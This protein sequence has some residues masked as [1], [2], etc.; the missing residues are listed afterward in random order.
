MEEKTKKRSA[1]DHFSDKELKQIREERDK[2]LAGWQRSQADFLNYKKGEG[3]K[4]QRIFDYKKEEWILELLD[5]LDLFDQAEK[6]NKQDKK[7]QGKAYVL[8]GFLQIK[9][10]FEDFLKR[11]GVQEI[12]IESGKEFNPHFEEVV[13]TVDGKEDGI[14]IEVVR[15]GYQINEKVIR[16]AQVKVTKTKNSEQ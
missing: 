16:V 14:I 2:Y 4:F 9:K 10:Y 3:E 15:K 8:E 12:I 5:I 13:E 7:E 11:H 6:Q 1:K